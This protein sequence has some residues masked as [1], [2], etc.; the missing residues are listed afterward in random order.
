MTL[1][2]AIQHCREQVQEQ[3][4]KGCYSCAEEHQQ[5][6]EL[7]KELKAYRE[8]DDDEELD[9]VPEHKKIPCTMIIG[10][11]CGDAISRQEVMDCFKKWQP[12][13]ATRLWDFEQELS[14][15]PT[16]TP[17]QRT[18]RWIEYVEPDDAEPLVLWRCDNCDTVERRK[19]LY[20]PQCGCRMEVKE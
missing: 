3:A 19:T 7:L 9:F 20:C 11:S 10:K 16:V 4:K 2:E 6:A 5:L 13:M 12:Y 17:Q 1:Q 18:G 14:A 15:L 8:Q